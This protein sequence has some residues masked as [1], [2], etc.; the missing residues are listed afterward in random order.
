MTPEQRFEDSLKLLEIKETA[1]G[2][3]TGAAKPVPDK[4]G[5]D[6]L[7]FDGGQVLRCCELNLH[8]DLLF[9]HANPDS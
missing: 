9:L 3:V 6:Q 5:I 8:E 1:E 2:V 4:A 7:L